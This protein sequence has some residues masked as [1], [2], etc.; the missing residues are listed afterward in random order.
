M[1]QKTKHTLNKIQ[2]HRLFLYYQYSLR[3]CAFIFYFKVVSQIK[4]C[5]QTKTMDAH[6]KNGTK[7]NKNTL[8]A[9]THAQTQ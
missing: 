3:F 9:H 2:Q 8:A 4:K 5:Q 6:A 7:K 1:A